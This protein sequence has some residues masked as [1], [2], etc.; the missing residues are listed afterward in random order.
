MDSTAFTAICSAASGAFAVI[1]LKGVEAYANWQ[2]A[3][4]D[5]WKIQHEAD[6]ADCL[7]D[8]DRADRAYKVIFA[9][10]RRQ[11]ARLEDNRVIDRQEYEKNTAQL[12]KEHQECLLMNSQLNERVNTQGERIRKLENRLNNLNERTS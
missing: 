5:A 2:R 8:D 7:A 4:T 11:I 1:A 10:M 12:R 6:A 3:R 9:E